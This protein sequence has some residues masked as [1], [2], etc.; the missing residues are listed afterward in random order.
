MRDKQTV[1][2]FCGD[3]T[4]DA[5]ALA[6]ANVGVHINL[7]SEIAQSAADA[8]L[9]R[10]ALSGILCLIDLSRAAVKRIIFNFCW[11]FTYNLF[12]VL[13]AAGLFVKWR[14]PPEYAALGEIISVLP[15]ITIA[16][17]ESMNSVKIG[18]LIQESGYLLSYN[19]EYLKQRNW[20][21]ICMMGESAQER[22]VSLLNALNRVCFKRR[23][24]KG[25]AIET[26]AAEKVAE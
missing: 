20:I 1:V 15:V 3:G 16:L 4:N 21:Q 19:S 7:G 14:I 5:P 12:A 10:P 8:V 23:G 2:M 25:D 9:V 11:S 17:P 26:V 22:L 6:Q 24:G 13:L 18:A